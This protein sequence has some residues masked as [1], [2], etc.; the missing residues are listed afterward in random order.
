MLSN[1]LKSN[2]PFVIVLI[3]LSGISL[4]FY[5]FIDPL[6]IAIPSDNMNMPFYDFITGYIAFNSIFSLVITYIL[7]L[8][9]AFLLVQFNI[10][11]REV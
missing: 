6:G 2:Q 3:I 11:R 4:W 1:I 8:I 10:S 7:V 5:S 9:Q